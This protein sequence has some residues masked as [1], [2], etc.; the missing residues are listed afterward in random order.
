MH[1]VAAWV[2]GLA[3]WEGG[4]EGGAETWMRRWRSS[5]SASR[6]CRTP[7]P[8]RQRPPDARHRHTDT[9]THRHTD[10]HPL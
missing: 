10:T 6:C 7:T 2:T 1:G 9:Q 8:P 5:M 3:I 4:R